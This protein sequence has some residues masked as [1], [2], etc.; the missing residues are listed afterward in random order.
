MN[1]I[2]LIYYDF[3]LWYF[4]LVNIGSKSLRLFIIQLKYI[5]FNTNSNTFIDYNVIMFIFVFTIIINEKK[6]F[7]LALSQ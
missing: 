4:N 7:F 1:K 6:Y 2:Q 5:R 3:K